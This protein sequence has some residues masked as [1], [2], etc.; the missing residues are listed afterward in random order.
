LREGIEYHQGPRTLRTTPFDFFAG[1][2]VNPYK[3]RE[4]DQM[5]QFYKLQLKIALGAQFIITQL[6]YN[7]RK[8]YELKQYMNREGL[9]HIPVLANVYVPTAK[10]ARMMQA[11]DVAGC[12]IPNELI[13]RLEGEKKPQRLERAALMVAAAKDLGFA[14]AHI[15][16][17]GLSHGDFM[18]ITE[19]AAAIGSGW[20][21]GLD[22]L[23][24]PYGNEF[25]LLPA[26]RGGLSVDSGDYQ[27]SHA[28]S[29]A[30]FTQWLSK[31]VHRYLIAEGS[32]GARFFAARLKPNGKTNSW[33]HGLWYR[34]LEVSTLYRKATLGCKGCGDCLQDHLD[35]AGC[36]MRWCYKELRNGPCGGSTV[37]G[38]CE[39]RP[40]QECIWNVIYRG[41][42]AMGDD[43]RKFAR[44]LIP[45]RDWR[46]DG[47]NALANRFA[48]MDNLDKR[49]DLGDGGKR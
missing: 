6:G 43:P 18:N 36:S 11:G 28:K 25:Y 49:V 31:Q 34:L 20:R 21:N 5:M 46:L 45:P 27:L 30:T 22:E 4:S 8:L 14:G 2:V 37:D 17:F 13:K 44:T 3:V 24:P 35:Y 9:G 41:T 38:F 29:H 19:R 1:A 15:G 26:S 33:R 48:G 42:L 12:V 47:T 32:P 7:L 40:E 16:G 23:M 39:A 10:I